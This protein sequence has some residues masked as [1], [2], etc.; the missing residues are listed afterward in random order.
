MPQDLQSFLKRLKDECPEQFLDVKEPV[1]REFE[2]TALVMEAERLPSC[3]AVMF[4]DVSGSEFPMAANV[5][6][7]RPRLAWAFGASE[8]RLVH[9]FKERIQQPVPPKV[10]KDAPF[11]ENSLLNESVDLGQL[12]ILTHFEQ[13]AAPT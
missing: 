11:Q 5:L 2:A 12:P 3:P 6:A 7:H 10:F 13:T 4:H 9:E 1:S 8:E